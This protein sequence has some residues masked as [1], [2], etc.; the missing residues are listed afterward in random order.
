MPYN[1]TQELQKLQPQE[2]KGNPVYSLQ[3]AERYIEV[4]KEQY[5]KDPSIQALTVND[6]ATHIGTKDWKS[7]MTETALENLA[8]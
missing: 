4:I 5:D 2:I 1:Y 8:K 6:L 7:K 3:E